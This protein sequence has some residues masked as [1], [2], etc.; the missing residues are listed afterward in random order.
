VSDLI[1]DVQGHVTE[2]RASIDRLF[3]ASKVAAITASIQQELQEDS[4]QRTSPV[5]LLRSAVTRS[6]LHIGVALQVLQQLAGINTVMCVLKS[7]T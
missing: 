1:L 3:P 4:Q 2:C 7:C 6:Q 5:A